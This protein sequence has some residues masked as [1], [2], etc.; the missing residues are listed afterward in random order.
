MPTYQIP[1]VIA[2]QLDQ[3]ELPADVPI[4][5]HLNE[6]P[7]AEC[8]KE[9]VQQAVRAFAALMRHTQKEIEHMVAM[10]A[11]R[12]RRLAHLQAYLENFDDIGWVRR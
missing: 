6:K 3:L 4:D 1:D 11:R 8:S 9:E 5:G 2:V 7:L 10:H 12:R